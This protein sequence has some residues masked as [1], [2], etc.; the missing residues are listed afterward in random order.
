MQGSTPNN[1][2]LT[3]YQALG[4]GE[5]DTAHPIQTIPVYYFHSF[6]Q[7]F[8]GEEQCKCHW[9]QQ[10]AWRLLMKVVE[11]HV[12]L[13]QAADLIDDERIGEV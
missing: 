4:G 1:L 8:C 11:G 9:K 6:D 7:P 5:A 10:D 3:E 2:P 12:T 13:E